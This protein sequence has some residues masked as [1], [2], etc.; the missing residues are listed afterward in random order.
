MQPDVPTMA[1]MVS[2]AILTMSGATLWLTRAQSSEGLNLWGGGLLV[3]AL[4]LPVLT[5][6]PMI[7]VNFSIIVGNSLFSLSIGLMLWGYYRF[8]ERRPNLWLTLGPVFLTAICMWLFLDR[9]GMRVMLNGLI[10]GTQTLVLAA[11]M[12]R[13]RQ[14]T[15]GHGY[16]LLLCG[17]LMS[18]LIC[19]ARF[20]AVF[21]GAVSSPTSD[22]AQLLQTVSFIGA[23]SAAMLDAVGFI[24]MI[25]ERADAR[26]RTL[27]MFDE[28]TGIA[29]RRAIR[30]EFARRSSEARRHRRSLSVLMIDIDHFKEVNDTYGHPAGDRVLKTVAHLIGSRLRAQDALG[31][32]GG[33]E[34]LVVLP[35]TA[36]EAGALLAEDLCQCI[37]ATP[38]DLG[39]G[40]SIHISASIGVAGVPLNDTRHSEDIIRASDDALYR[41]KKLGRNR[42]EEGIL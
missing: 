4:A 36:Q 24:G 25:K 22:G 13:H 35:N 7:P 6:R 40:I 12:Y 9:L 10:A 34:F 31:R 18:T 42:V 11:I 37:A 33:E 38:I 20:L 32:Y 19:Y 3:Y 17:C 1:M 39:D 29:N 8:L 2:V 15:P 30:D 26:N 23:L 14:L 41:A 21:S 27:A 5:L 16:Q 28:L